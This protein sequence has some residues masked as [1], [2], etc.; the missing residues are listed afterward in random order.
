MEIQL[1]VSVN[2]G[3][4]IIAGFKEEFAGVTTIVRAGR[5]PDENL[6]V[7]ANISGMAKS[8]EKITNWQTISLKVGD[9]VRIRIVDNQ[10]VS[11]PIEQK[12]V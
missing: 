9:E 3:T 11:E 1:E 5:R 10:K 6:E 4:P 7:Y 8:S 2:G 12:P